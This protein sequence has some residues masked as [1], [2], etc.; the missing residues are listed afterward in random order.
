MFI[1]D[2]F[3]EKEKGADGKACWSGYR[4]AGTRNGKDK[5]VKINENSASEAIQGVILRRIIHQ[6]PEVLRKYGPDACMAAAE[7]VADEVGDIEEIGSS[8]VSAYT[9][10]A[11]QLCSNEE[12]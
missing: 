2:L 3:E 11:I 4:Y 12:M 10:R 6:Y 5:C 1:A 7:Q 9:K 8:D